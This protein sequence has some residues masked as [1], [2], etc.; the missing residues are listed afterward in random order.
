MP[1]D[2]YGQPADLDELLALGVPVVEDAAHAAESRYRGRKVGSISDVTCF[3]ALRDEEHRRRRGRADRDE[4][5]RPRR[6]A[7][8]S[9]RDAPRPRLALRHRRSRLQGEP[10]RRA[11]VDRARAARQGRPRTPR[12]APATSRSTRRAS[13]TSTGSSRSRATRAT[14]TRTTSSSS[15]STPRCGATRDDVPAGADRREHRH[16]DPLSAGAPADGVPRAARAAPAAAAGHRA[17]RRRGAVAAALAG[18]LGRGRSRRGRG[19]AARPRA[20]RRMKRALRIAATLVVSG[21]AV[22]YILTRRSTS[23]R[24]SHIIGSASVP[25]LAALGGAHARHG[26]ADGVALAAAARVRGVHEQ[27]AVADAR[28]LRLVRRRAGAAD[29]GRRRRV[30]DLRDERA[31]TAGR[32]R[33][34]PA[35]CWSSGRSAGR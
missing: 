29:V 22:A 24:R 8:R 25:W 11:R 28:V 33:R 20:L 17:G 26:A 23:G 19:A 7:R 32:S 1:V 14:C 15:A 30:A 9:A 6:R 21:A 12:S 27:R 31:G 4:P 13:P 3:S 18:A 10:P 35:R 34:S 2:L 16:V 5:R